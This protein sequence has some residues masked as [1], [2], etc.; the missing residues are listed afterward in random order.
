M[1]KLKTML[2]ILVRTMMITASIVII[3]IVII[4][5]MLRQF[6]VNNLGGP[7]TRPWP[8]AVCPAPSPN[9]GHSLTVHTHSLVSN[10]LP[11]LSYLQA[12]M[13]RKHLRIIIFN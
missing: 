5:V 4:I 13:A 9:S 2:I 7:L 8:V 3:I 6:I 12:Y 10:Q 11:F 1:M